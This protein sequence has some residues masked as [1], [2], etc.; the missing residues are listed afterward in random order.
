MSLPGETGEE[1]LFVELQPASSDL[2]SVHGGAW[3]AEP[4][5]HTQQSGVTFN[6]NVPRRTSQVDAEIKRLEELV[7][8]LRRTLI[9][10]STQNQLL[11]VPELRAKTVGPPFKFSRFGPDEKAYVLSRLRDYKSTGGSQ[12]EFCSGVGISKPTIERWRASYK[13]YGEAGLCARVRRK[14]PS[15]TRAEETKARILEIFHSQP[16]D[17]RHQ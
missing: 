7:V 12:S 2:G 3:V 14:F 8:H 10:Q 6:R 9:V 5:R 17:L 4:R 13:R 11:R 1:A 16:R 15:R